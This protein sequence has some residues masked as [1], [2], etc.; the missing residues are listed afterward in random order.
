[1][2]S[3]MRDILFDNKKL[4]EDVRKHKQIQRTL[5]KYIREI[6]RRK[7]WQKKGYNSLLEYC[8][9]EYGYSIEDLKEM[10]LEDLTVLAAK[11]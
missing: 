2:R 9:K 8:E 6:H 7:L 10:G 1:M 3:N 5:G 4:L 11:L